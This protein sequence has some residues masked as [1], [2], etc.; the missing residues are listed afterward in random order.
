MP[1]LDKIASSW[2]VND[3]IEAWLKSCPIRTNQQELWIALVHD[4]IEGRSNG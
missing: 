2:L 3:E 4:K 1:I